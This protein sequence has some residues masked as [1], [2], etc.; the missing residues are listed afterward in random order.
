MVRRARERGAEIPRR[1]RDRLALVT[2]M[3]ARIDPLEMMAATTGDLHVIRNAGGI[4][5]DDV[6]RSLWISQM[7]L[8]TE[9]VA[10]VMHT[11]CGLLGLDAEKMIDETRM[12]TD[13]LPSFGPNAFDDLEERLAASIEAVRSAEYLPHRAMISG[14]IFDVMTRE[15]MPVA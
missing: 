11:D 15:L 12:G 1:P 14:A 2:C 13:S 10:I 7:Q 6:L 4:V 9:R 5:T 8:G 3:D